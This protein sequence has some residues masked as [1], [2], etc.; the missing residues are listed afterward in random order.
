MIDSETSV[1]GLNQRLIPI[2]V[3][4]KRETAA[5]MNPVFSLVD[6]SSRLTKVSHARRSGNN[7]ADKN[8]VHVRF[9]QHPIT[10]NQH[11]NRRATI[12]LSIEGG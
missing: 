6:G 9:L 8:D 4:K 1:Y 5:Q 12:V 10:S 7:F 2:R 3:P 11:P